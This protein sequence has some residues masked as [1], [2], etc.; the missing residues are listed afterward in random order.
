MKLHFSLVAR[1]SLGNIGQ[2]TRASTPYLRGN[3]CQSVSM[4]RA[5]DLELAEFD[6]RVLLDLLDAGCED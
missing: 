2:E 3:A 5:K 1:D 4:V 6:E